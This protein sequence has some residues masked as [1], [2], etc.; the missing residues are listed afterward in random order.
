MSELKS[1]RQVAGETG[2]GR[3][4]PADEGMMGSSFRIIKVRGISIGAHWSWLLVFGL[5][6]WSLSSELFPRA[7]PDLGQRAYLFM[8]IAAAAI[9]FISIILHELGHAFQALKEGMKVGDI[10]LWLFGGV[11][12]FE[13]M[14]PS[15]GAEFRVAIAGPVVSLVLAI[16]FALLGW[17]GSALD[18]PAQLRGVA[19]YLAR[20]NGAVLAFNL[21]PAL[22]LDGGRV[23]RSWLWHRQ[24]SFSAATVSAAR[25]GKLFA[26]ILMTVGIMGFFTRAVTG[27]IWLVFLG[28]FILQAAEAEV[29]YALITRAFRPHRVRDLMTPG[30]VVVP[31]ELSISEFLDLVGSRGY[32]TYPV[33][34]EAGGLLGLVSVRL[35]A[36]Q[37][38]AD[39]TQLK[40]RDVMLPADEVPKLNPD[41]PMMEAL[42]SLRSGLNRA[43]VMENGRVTGILSVSDVARSLEIEQA[44]GGLAEPG[45][46]KAGAAVWIVVGILMALAAAS[47][48]HPPLAVI[49]PAPA[50]D[51][52]DNISI[53]GVA[54]QKPNGKYLL[55]AVAVGQTNTLGTLLAVVDPNKEVIPLSAIVPEGISGREFDEQQ[56]DLFAESQLLAAAAA[57]NAAGLEVA[58]KGSGARVV[59]LVPGSPASEVLISGDVIVAVDGV[60]VQQAYDLR[61]AVSP[62]APGTRFNLD[63]E[64]RGRRI[65]LQVTSARIDPQVGAP[66][67]IGVLVTTRDFDVDL[68]FEIEFEELEVGGP[69]AGLAYAL[70]IAD[71]LDPGDYAEGRS[72]AASGTISADGRVGPVGG[73]N[74]KAEAAEQG[75][76]DILVV[77]QDEIG[78]VRRPDVRLRGVDTL[79][80]AITVLAPT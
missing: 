46:R 30:P 72:I 13:G 28:F 39:R 50:I 5:V 53:T 52:T 68:P 67:G 65:D 36:K 33:I 24:R 11:A 43:V 19:Q 45:A 18:A 4:P 6:S 14:F 10:T 42:S 23:L 12:R 29:Q 32:S 27:G 78:S 64:R 58:L 54:T 74:Q 2:P 71:M 44:R 17:A 40:V 57:A 49:S 76:A 79:S 1:D 9:F 73:L 3:R 37:P 75:R 80:E 35:V 63:V 25:A 59:D 69:S 7:Y 21:V 15:P 41:T 77:P 34:D 55:L 31:P 20:I 51:I 22:P 16:G 8:G 48:Y 61:E 70:A 66:P 62:R 60:P 56:S 47:F 38:L 26:Y